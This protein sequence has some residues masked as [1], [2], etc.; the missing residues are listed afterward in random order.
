VAQPTGRFEPRDDP[1]WGDIAQRALV[2]N[3][4]ALDKLAVQDYRAAGVAMANGVIGRGGDIAPEV[5]AA[6][7]LWDTVPETADPTFIELIGGYR[8]TLREHQE[9]GSDA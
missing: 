5:Q 9:R 3:S 2:D 1:R 4:E 6:Q 8:D 7:L